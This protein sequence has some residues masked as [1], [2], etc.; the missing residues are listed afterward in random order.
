MVS[1]NIT[2]LLP[3]LKPGG[4]L[5]APTPIV[6]GSP[7]EADRDWETSYKDSER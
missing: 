4:Y 2:L 7:Q 6:I 5:V 3:N 1:P